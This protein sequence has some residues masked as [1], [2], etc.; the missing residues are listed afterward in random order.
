MTTSA[1]D[2]GA[3]PPSNP[4]DPFPLRPD[5]PRV[6]RLC[7]KVPGGL[8]VITAPGIGGALIFALQDRPT[9]DGPGELFTAD[10][11]PTADELRRLPLDYSGIPQLAPP[12]PAISDDRSCAHRTQVSPSRL[13]QGSRLI[14]EYDNGLGFG[15]RRILLVWIRVVLPDGRS[16][17]LER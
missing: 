17:V 13:R 9:R 3:S 6:V 16:I 8:G 2:P 10:N 11:R 7:R 1:S 14:G 4:S 5:P 15:Q 12:C